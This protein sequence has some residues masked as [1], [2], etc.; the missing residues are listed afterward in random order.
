VRHT[1]TTAKVR[2]TASA[3]ARSAHLHPVH[4][5]TSNLRCVRAVMP[6][7]GV[8][9]GWRLPTSLIYAP[10]R[11]TSGTDIGSAKGGRHQG[12]CA[13]RRLVNLPLV[14]VIRLWAAVLAIAYNGTLSATEGTQL[15]DIT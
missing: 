3:I 13:L 8:S 6:S 10:W 4:C 11:R 5:Q 1:Q 9:A 12:A 15:H 14:V 2:S 7:D